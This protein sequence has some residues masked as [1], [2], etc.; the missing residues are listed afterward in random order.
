MLND[1]VR[2]FKKTGIVWR[3]P[4]KN[5]YGLSSEELPIVAQAI[6]R[7]HDL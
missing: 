6:K 2:F 3:I 7:N 4:K 5:N 1:L